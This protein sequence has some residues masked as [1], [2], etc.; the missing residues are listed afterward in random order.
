MFSVYRII[1][2][3][4]SLLILTN[5]GG[6]QRARPGK[7]GRRTLLLDAKQVGDFPMGEFIDA[8][9]PKHGPISI[10]KRFDHLSK[11][12]SRDSYGFF[13]IRFLRNILFD[14][15]HVQKLLGQ[16]SAT[17]CRVERQIERHP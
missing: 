1:L 6:E 3:R 5:G 15:L 13:I 16:P 7:I 17:L 9:K 12:L 10:R 11:N 14:C 8:I 4:L 2:R